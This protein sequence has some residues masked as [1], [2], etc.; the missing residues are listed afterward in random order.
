MSEDRNK[1]DS[2]GKGHKDGLGHKTGGKERAE[3][4][5]G[6]GQYI[7]DKVRKEIDK[8]EK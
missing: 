3:G 5:R 2:A 7:P 1:H 8:R 4:K 6:M